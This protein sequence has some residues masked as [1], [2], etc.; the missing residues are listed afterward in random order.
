MSTLFDVAG[1]DVAGVDSAGPPAY[2]RHGPPAGA[3]GSDGAW[4]SA[5]SS[6]AREH[7]DQSGASGGVAGSGGRNDRGARG[8]GNDWGFSERRVPPPV[9]SSGELLAVLDRMVHLCQELDVAGLG[10]P[11]AINLLTSMKRAARFLDGA[12]LSTI[13]HIDEL[14]AIQQAQFDQLP[15][16][17]GKRLPLPGSERTLG[18]VLTVSGQQSK[19]QTGREI[20]Q[21]RAATTFPLFRAAMKKGMSRSYLEALTSVVGK[22][23]E[24]QARADEARLLESAWN[25]PVERFRKTVLAWRVTQHPVKAEKDAMRE[26]KM[27]RFSVSPDRDG[28][29]LSGWLTASNGTVLKHALNEIVGV[30]KRED[31]RSPFQRNAEAL[32]VLASASANGTGISDRPT[33]P[34]HEILVHVPLDTLVRTERAVA[35]GCAAL[36]AV[37]GV[38]VMG[39]TGD[40][41]SLT[42]HGLGRRGA[43][44]N[45]GEMLERDLGG[46]LSRIRAGVDVSLLEGYTP[47][48][49]P[50]GSAVPASELAQLLCDS[51][52]TRVVMTA[53]GDPLD[54]S[55]KQR[56]FS[57]KQS[58]AVV[59]RDRYCRYPGC[60]RGPTYGEIHHAQ[61]HEK[62]GPTTIDNAV[63]LCRAHHGV[64]HRE[65]ITIAHHLGGFAFTGPDGTLVGIT[66]HRSARTIL[67][68]DTQKE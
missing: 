59:A 6:G 50:D 61:E 36:P 38:S 42:G 4:G 55:R 57:P 67:G 54:V 13:G 19:A 51:T 27:E 40:A 11:E 16:G 28:Y 63:L 68:V 24:T 5:G 14:H 22:D 64:I 20:S 12:R 37:D 44:L 65:Q 41:C 18:D 52:I 9:D 53:Y 10:L 49:L 58:K 62:G 46:V 8:S 3:R 39:S 7:L 26:V 60:E 35:Q 1:V 15:E 34:R 2:R 21:A 47:A 23:L 66:K 48:T 56:P 25:E 17:N 30:P 43:C 33:A 29:R 32:T 45:Q 31:R